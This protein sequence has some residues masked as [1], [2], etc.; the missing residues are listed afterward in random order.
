MTFFCR[1]ETHTAQES[2][3]QL[4]CHAVMSFQFTDV[5]S[6]VCGGGLQKSRADC[7]TVGLYCV[8]ITRQ[9]IGNGPPILLFFK[10]RI[11]SVPM[12]V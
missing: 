1:Y 9:Q 8:T 11:A 5:P 10:S 12:C 7:S 6:F 4:W 2:G 3:S